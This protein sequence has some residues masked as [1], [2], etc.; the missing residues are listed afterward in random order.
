M[1]VS[2]T[3]ATVVHVAKLANLPISADEQAVL[4]GTFQQTLEEIDALGQVDVTG[5]EP[6]HSVS[7]LLNVWRDDTVDSETTLTQQQALSQ[8]PRTFQGFI[9]VDRVLE[10]QS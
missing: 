4:V 9:V 8:A 5:V 6:T 3:P 10:D 2:V 1:S 7:G